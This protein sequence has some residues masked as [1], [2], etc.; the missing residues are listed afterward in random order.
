MH[1]R[2]R[3]VKNQLLFLAIFL[4]SIIFAHFTW[5]I[6]VA[7][8]FSMLLGFGQVDDESC[9]FLKD[10]SPEVLLCLGKRALG[11]YESLVIDLGRRVDIVSIDIGVI[12]ILITLNQA[13]FGMF[14]RLEVGV[15]VHGSPSG[16]LVG[17]M[18]FCFC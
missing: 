1:Q 5:P 8:D 11:S 2:L 4:K 14:E 12:D 17:K 18:L 15:A 6:L 13:H 7:L 16:L 10:H 9:V 3:R